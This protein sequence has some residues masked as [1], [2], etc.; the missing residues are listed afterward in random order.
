MRRRQFLGVLGAAATWPVAARAQQRGLPVIGLL[1]S[2]SAATDT[3]LIAVFR[4]ALNE[5][6]FV[7]GQNVVIDYRWADGQ[8]DRLPALAT[9]LVR[10]QVA[11]IVTIGGE[12]SGLA[13]KAAT[14]TIPIVF[15]A[16]TDPVAI[17]LVSSLNRPGGNITGHKCDVFRADGQ[18]SGTSA[19]ACPEGF[20]DWRAGEPVL[21]GL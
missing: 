4:Q 11:V 6:G 12:V 17:G 9:S 14:A 19:G 8:Y 16:G 1:S 5:G 18:T 3:N 13:A 15:V 20:V 10:R 2:R 7:E 21:F